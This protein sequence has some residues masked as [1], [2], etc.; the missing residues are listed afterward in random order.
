MVQNGFY[1]GLSFY[2][3][4]PG[5]VI[6][7]GNQVG[8][9]VNNPDEYTSSSIFSDPGVLAFAN[10]GD[11]TNQSEFFITTTTTNSAEV[12]QQRD[13]DF[14]FTVLGQ[15]VRGQSVVDLIS[16]QPASGQSRCT[17]DHH[18]VR[19]DRQRHRR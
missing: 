2:R 15:V 10:S 6:Q 17:A 18:H 11:N 7:G 14:N 4:V 13:L 3:I 16:T 19:A 9:G 8:T 1:N 5:F 12:L